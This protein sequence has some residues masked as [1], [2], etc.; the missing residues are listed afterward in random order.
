MFIPT[1][2]EIKEF[3]DNSID[4]WMERVRLQELPEYTQLKENPNME[5]FKQFEKH[6][7]TIGACCG[8]AM[9]TGWLKLLENKKDEINTGN[10]G[11][12]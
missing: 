2:E 4:Y 5:F 9:V 3:V 12:D 11:K 7:I 6:F 10:D 8:V 1:N